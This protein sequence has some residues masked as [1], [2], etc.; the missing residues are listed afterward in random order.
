MEF[1]A[2]IA[3][4]QLH[5]LPD[6]RQGPLLDDEKLTDRSAVE[7][8]ISGRF[9]EKHDVREDGLEENRIQPRPKLGSQGS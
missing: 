4:P 5:S 6:M 2:K 1:Q 9:E 8:V 7:S 3:E